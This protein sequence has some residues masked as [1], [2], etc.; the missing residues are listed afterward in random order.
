MNLQTDLTTRLKSPA[1]LLAP[2]L[3]LSV[4]DAKSL[5]ERAGTIYN[6]PKRPDLW[7]QFSLGNGT[8]ATFTAMLELAGRAQ[9]DID[10]RQ[11]ISPETCGEDVAN[12]FTRLQSLTHEELW[13]LYIDEMGRIMDC[14]LETR[15][16][17]N[18]AGN[19]NNAI[20]RKCVLSGASAVIIIHNHPTGSPRPSGMGPFFGGDM[21][22][23]TELYLILK[24]L[25]V[26]LYDTVIVGDA[27]YW[28]GKETGVLD[29]TIKGIEIERRKAQE[30]GDQT[31]SMADLLM[32][33]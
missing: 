19:P 12:Y 29:E 6:I 15:G 4:E 33:F 30:H 20:A 7:K 25:R 22:V 3:S 11:R 8:M 1:E 24:T 18:S 17:E 27:S 14:V 21:A 28:S 32:N 13:C 9:T 31:K 5:L 10:K 26:K 2:V 16:D 23:F